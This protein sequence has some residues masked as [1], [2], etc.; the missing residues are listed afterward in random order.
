MGDAT[1]VERQFGAAL[2]TA[3]ASMPGD[4]GVSRDGFAA[5][6]VG[7]TPEEANS[8]LATINALGQQLLGWQDLANERQREVDVLTA[9]Q[10]FTSGESTR[11]NEENLQIKTLDHGQANYRAD[12]T[13]K[14]AQA[15]NAANYAQRERENV[16]GL[17]AG[18]QQLA[19]D[20]QQQRITGIEG[21]SKAIA[22]QSM[23]LFTTL[24]GS[25]LPPSQP[26]ARIGGANIMDFL[27]EGVG[28]PLPGYAEVG[29][30]LQLPDISA[31]F[32]E[33]LALR[34]QQAPPPLD[35]GRA[36]GAVSKIAPEIQQIVARMLHPE[37]VTP[38]P[39][40]PS[41]YTPIARQPNI[42]AS[43][44]AVKSVV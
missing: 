38:V 21:I 32:A 6:L 9:Q 35:I 39:V 28:A 12:I 18:Q 44:I 36:L 31:G 4:I 33:A 25:P 23:Q 26:G 41:A 13:R 37:A 34:R 24:T 19:A 2:D 1:E 14:D 8:S 10:A 3:W 29:G 42:P 27:V 20:V 5:G 43:G 40:P 16:I 30:P 15:L 7:K 11:R 22:D 17:A